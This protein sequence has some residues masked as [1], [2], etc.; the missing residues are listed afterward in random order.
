MTTRERWWQNWRAQLRGMLPGVRA[1]RVDGLA[2]L[3]V[4][5]LLAKHVALTRMAEAV[6]MA[7]DDPSI[8]RRL[9][10]W[11]AN[12]DVEAD[13]IWA[14]L[15]P[16]VLAGVRRARPIFVFDPTPQLDQ[17]TVLVVG[18]VQHRRV[19]PV[20]W[21]LV[22]QQAAWP[23][24]MEALLR[25]MLTEIAAALPPGTI[26]TL[27][28]DRGITSAA[29][30]DL[31]RELGWHFV[32]RVN[33]GPNQTNRARLADG[34]EQRLWELVTTPGQRLAQPVALFKDAGWRALALT[35]HWTRGEDEPWILVSDDAAGPARVAAYRQRSRC[36][37]TYL[38]VKS[39][40]WAIEETKLTDPAR[41]DRLLLGL[42]VAFCWAHGLGLRVIRAG[43]RH[44]YDRSDRRDK[45]VIKLGWA[46]LADRLDH[47]R[48]P[49]L[50]FTD[51]AGTWQLS[52]AF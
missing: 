4:G 5:L 35:I 24:P 29:M 31:C 30:V 19:L 8:E 26:P 47:Q 51:R 45:S 15:L 49:A 22:P 7:A 44:R 11:V 23:A 42:H 18:V 33:A 34:E 27:L 37:A 36:E 32:F 17:F 3:V 21:R 28:V 40:G 14:Q 38:D 41:L 43:Q 9:R 6:P 48:L 39:R 1:T 10:R 25:A 46:V 52:Y 50:L 2:L 20:A 16:A 12:D 13:V